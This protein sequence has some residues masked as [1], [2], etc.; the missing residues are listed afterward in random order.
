MDS[1][2]ESDEENEDSVKIT[3]EETPTGESNEEEQ[4]ERVQQQ[5]E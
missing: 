4:T 5:C 3:R 1:G 2:I